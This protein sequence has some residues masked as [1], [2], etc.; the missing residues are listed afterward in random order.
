MSSQSGEPLPQECQDNNK[1]TSSRCDTHTHPPTLTCSRVRRRMMYASSST[2]WCGSAY[3][4]EM[5]NVAPCMLV[6]ALS[7]GLRL[8]GASRCMEMRAML[9]GNMAKAG[10]RSR[11]AYKQ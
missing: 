6:G 2:V 4:S 11:E 9:G 5:S 3:S 7:R 10:S 1:A 8:Q